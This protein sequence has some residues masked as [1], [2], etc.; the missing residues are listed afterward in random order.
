M[1]QP[2]LASLKSI[3]IIYVT[4]CFV[5]E[6]IKVSYMDQ[7]EEES[8]GPTLSPKGK[9]EGKG[10]LL[11]LPS[12]KDRSTVMLRRGSPMFRTNGNNVSQSNFYTLNRRFQTIPEEATLLL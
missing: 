6:G 9:I 3:H 5:Q 12:P 8:D 2:C 4:E 11:L 7:G 1:M 10:M